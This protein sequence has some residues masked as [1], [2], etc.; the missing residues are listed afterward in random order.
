VSH[1]F[2]SR[3]ESQAGKANQ[4]HNEKV[5]LNPEEVKVSRRR[6]MPSVIFHHVKAA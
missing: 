6:N 3:H 2:S 4:E 5:L 1:S